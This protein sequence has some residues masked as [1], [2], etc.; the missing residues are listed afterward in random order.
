MKIT[1][2]TD[3]HFNE[4]LGKDLHHFKKTVTIELEGHLAKVAAVSYELI[5]AAFQSAMREGEGMPTMQMRHIVPGG[6][7]SDD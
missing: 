1:I 6:G 5:E 3:N 4:N 2:T 7:G